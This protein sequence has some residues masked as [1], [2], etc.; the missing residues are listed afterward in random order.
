MLIR[1]HN[2]FLT[3]FCNYLEYLPVY[4]MIKIFVS[5]LSLSKVYSRYLVPSLS[6]FQLT[7]HR[8]MDRLK[9]KTKL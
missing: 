1:Y 6:C 5:L 7:I 3:I 4:S 2:S 9:S 8:M